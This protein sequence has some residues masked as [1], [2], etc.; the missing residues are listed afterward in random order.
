MAFD[1]GS[2]LGPLSSGFLVRFGLMVPF[3]FGAVLAAVG[4]VLVYTQVEESISVS[5]PFT[6]TIPDDSDH[7]TCR[8]V[9]NHED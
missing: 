7:H 8:S 9:M 5:H 2:A 3:A 6:S 4:A 1:L